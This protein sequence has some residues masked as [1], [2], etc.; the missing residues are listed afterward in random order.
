MKGERRCPTD[1]DRNKRK[2][3][4]WCQSRWLNNMTDWPDLQNHTYTTSRKVLITPA[5]KPKDPNTTRRV[6]S[7]QYQEKKR[8][9]KTIKYSS[10]LKKQEQRKQKKVK[11]KLEESR[12]DRKTERKR[13]EDRKQ[14]KIQG[15]EEGDKEKVKRRKWKRTERRQDGWREGCLEI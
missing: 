11:E 9:A 4:R 13:K 14:G 10:R 15:K 12:K 3:G 1:L 8:W 5:D 6:T 7:E 2:A